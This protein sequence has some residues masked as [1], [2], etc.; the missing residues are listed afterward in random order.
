MKDQNKPVTILIIEDNPSDA[1]LLEQMLLLSGLTIEKTYTA[2][3]LSEAILILNER[4]IS[5]VF[6]DL[7]LPD[8][9][10]IDSFLQI[11]SIVQK[12]PVII[13][14]GLADFD[15]ASE[16][17]KQG[18]QDYLVKGDFNEGTLQ[19][20][21]QYSTERKKAEELQ[22]LSEEKYRQIFYKNPFPMWIYDKDTTRIIGANDA[23]LK[24]YC[25]ERKEFLNLSVANLQHPA[26]K[27]V[28]T[29]L[30]A[31]DMDN[32]AVHKKKNGEAILV[33]ITSY[34]IDYFGKIAIQVQTNDITEKA[35]LQLELAEKKQQMIEAVLNAQE[36]ERKTIGEELHDNVNQILTAVK[37]TLGCVLDRRADEDGLVTKSINSVSLAIEEIR[38]LSRKLVVPG[39]LKELGLLPSLEILI[40]DI[41]AVTSISIS[42]ETQGLEKIK[43]VQDQKVAIYRIVQEQ[44]NNIIKYAQASTVMIQLVLHDHKIH[45]SITDNG[46]GF[47]TNTKRK[48]IGLYNMASRAELFGGKLDIVSSPGQ[49]C[50]LLVSINA[51]AALAVERA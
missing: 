20:A 36:Y 42:I 44:L 38:R 18:A 5:L 35:R 48:G 9:F 30:V 21:V 26:P 47:D 1:Y 49:G 2:Q 27:A 40:K 13:L 14:T 23:A 51:K 34:P 33:E 7:S 41:E 11:K 39:N 19:K 46:K 31:D 25:Y 8:S 16:A 17:L 3:R 28:L 6:L 32:I 4:A 24:T 22:L 50:S 45:L 37:L 12:I 10:G 29:A 43:I 15:L